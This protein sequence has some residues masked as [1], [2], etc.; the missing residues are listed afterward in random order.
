MKPANKAWIGGLLLAAICAPGC[1]KVSEQAQS[2]VNYVITGH[3]GGAY[4]PTNVNKYNLED[5]VKIVM[6][7]AGVQRSVTCSSIRERITEDGRLEITANL[8]NRQNRRIEVQVNCVFK[9]A[10]GFPTND[11]APFRTLILTEN[12]Q[13]GVSFISLNDLAKTYTIRVRQ[14]R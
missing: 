3:A 9:D 8:R 1:M 10:D 4:D 11:E 6:L 12:A 14:A 2:G 7:D 13:E 5:S